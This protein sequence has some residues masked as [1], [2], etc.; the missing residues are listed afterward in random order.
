MA[1]TA[2]GTCQISPTSPATALLSVS[3]ETSAADAVPVISPSASSVL[4]DWPS[5][6]VATYSFSVS[7]RYPSSLVAFFTPT[8]ST[9]VAIGSSVPACPTFLVPA[10]RRTRATTSCD[11]MPP[12]LST[13]TRPPPTSPSPFTG[14][15][16]VIGL[17]GGGLTVGIGVTG[18]HGALAAAGEFGVGVPSL[19]DQVLDP[20]G[21]LRQH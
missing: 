19:G 4:V 21:G 17:V 9:P 5:L 8:T 2:G 3:A 15:R 11:V 6:I 7:V 10:S 13:M 16:V 1:L 20:L 14:S 18:G 12:G